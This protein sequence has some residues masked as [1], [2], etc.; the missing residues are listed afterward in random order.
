[1]AEVDRALAELRR[2]AKKLQRID[3]ER[4]VAMRERDAALRAAREARATGAELQEASGLTPA[5]I[6]K[7]LRRK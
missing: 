2:A 7:A 1:M 3:D 4:V 5:T 6:T